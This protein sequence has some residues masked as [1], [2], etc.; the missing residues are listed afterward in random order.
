MSWGKYR[1]VKN[2]FLPIENEVTNIDKDCVK[3]LSLYL[4]K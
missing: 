4:T 2:F 1:N 3:V